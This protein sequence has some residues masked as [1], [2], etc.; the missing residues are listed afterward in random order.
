MWGIV[1]IVG[2][3]TYL[4]NAMASADLGIRAAIIKL[5]TPIFGG[6]G[7]IPLTFI[8]IVVVVIATNFCNGLPL[9]LAAY[10]GVLPFVCQLAQTEG[11]SASVIATV[12]NMSANMAFLTYAS[13]ITAS[14]LLGRPEIEQ[15]WIWSKGVRVVPVFIVVL[16][17]VSMVLCRVLP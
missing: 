14:L 7:L 10:A 1:V 5:L 2:C 6:M 4:G 11:I 13:T 8:C 16:F 9:V 17:C 15:K 3:F 12:V